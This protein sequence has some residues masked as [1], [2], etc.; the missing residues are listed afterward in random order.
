[1]GLFSDV[2]GFID[3]GRAA[4]S[5]SDSNVAAEHGVLNA[6]GDAQN[7]V[8]SALGASRGTTESALGTANTNLQN[9]G[10]N[11]NNA[12]ADANTGLQTNLANAQAPLQ[13]GIQSGAQGN[14]MLQDY[15]ASNPQFNFNLQDY[16]NSPAMKFQLQTGTD[17]ITNAKAAMGLN[18]SSNELTDLTN[19]GQGLAST[20][21]QQAFND[22]QQQFQTNQNT[23]LA[24]ANALINSGN[25]S[26]ALNSNLA[27]SFG[28][29][30]SA[31][32]TNAA[33]ENANLATYGAGL[34]TGTELALG[35]QGV[36]GST[37]AGQEGIQ[38][39]TTA[40][41][42]AVGA[43]TAHSAGILG[44]GAALDSGVTDLAGLLSPV[45]G[46]IP[47]GSGNATTL[48]GILGGR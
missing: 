20:Y 25:T 4:K 17:A 32:T 3:T 29:P 42:F 22:A 11:I 34:N 9:A 28:I 23:T 26:N 24:N 31:N 10:T 44:Q 6:T 27:T 21:Y 38:G 1:M 19:Y 8:N 7:A 47:I 30:Q 2:T 35:Q 46:S 14:K 33:S 43:G 41:N 36:Q 45:I 18:Q 39:A 15:A 37:I 5:I 13:P 48:S 40:G 12:A 16:L